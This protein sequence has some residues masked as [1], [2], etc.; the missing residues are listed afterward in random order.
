MEEEGKMC[1]LHAREMELK[2]STKVEVYKVLSVIEAIFL[3]PVEQVNWDF[4]RD[5]LCERKKLED[6]PIKCTV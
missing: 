5:I 3:L 1:I 4:V 2:C 6:F